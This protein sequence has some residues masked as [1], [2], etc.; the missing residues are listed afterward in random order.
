VLQDCEK[1]LVTGAIVSLDWSGPPRA[2]IL[3]LK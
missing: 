2:R 3:P 1:D